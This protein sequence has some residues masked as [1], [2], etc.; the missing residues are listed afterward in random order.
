MESD[1]HLNTSVLRTVLRAVIIAA[2]VLAIIILCALIFLQLNAD[3]LVAG[4]RDRLAEETGCRIETG[5]IGLNVFPSPMLSVDGIT[6]KKDGLTFRAE[7]ASVR[8]SLFYLVRGEFRPE[9]FMLVRPSA[10]G[11]LPFLSLIHI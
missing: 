7:F 8:P 2:S 4:Y 10:R 5:S 9:H 3:S 6:V 11:T 1:V